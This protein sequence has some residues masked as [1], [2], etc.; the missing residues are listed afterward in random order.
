MPVGW[1]TRSVKNGFR[2][3]TSASRIHRKPQSVWY[4]SPA[5]PQMRVA[6]TRASGHVITSAIPRHATK[7]PISRRRR[8]IRS[9]GRRAC[10]TIDDDLGAETLHAVEAGERQ[11][12]LVEEIVDRV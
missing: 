2:N 8:L 3:E 4:G 11:V 6:K 1:K 9:P 12:E 7:G 10:R 5:S